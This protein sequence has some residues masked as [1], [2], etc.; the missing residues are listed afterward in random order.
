LAFLVVLV[1]P[2]LLHIPPLVSEDAEL[3]PSTFNLPNTGCGAA[4]GV[5]LFVFYYSPPRSH[6]VCLLGLARA[7]AAL[8]DR[9]TAE[10]AYGRLLDIW[11]ASSADD[12]SSSS[13]NAAVVASSP[14]APGIAEAEAY[15]LAVAAGEDDDDQEESGGGSRR[16][17]VAKLVY[18]LFFVGVTVVL[19]RAG[20]VLESLAAPRRP[21]ACA[22]PQTPSVAVVK[23]AT[24]TE[25]AATL[26]DCCLPGDNQAPSSVKGAASALVDGGDDGEELESGS[27]LLNMERGG[28]PKGAA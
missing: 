1:A 15:L 10:F 11:A 24:E 13:F 5:S 19:C 18:L 9:P 21:E 4:C 16:R 22:A 27:L 6:T 2:L 25:K 12:S 26:A 14:C 23:E 28:A 8:E 17:R 3:T 20:G 7:S